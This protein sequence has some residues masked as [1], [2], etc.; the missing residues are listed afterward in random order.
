M[1]GV[2]QYIILL[3]SCC[4]VQVGQFNDLTVRAIRPLKSRRPCWT[5]EF[6]I[7]LSHGLRLPRHAHQTASGQVFSVF[8]SHKNRRKKVKTKGLL[9]PRA[10]HTVDINPKVLKNHQIV[11]GLTRRVGMWRSRLGQ[12]CS[13]PHVPPKSFEALAHSYGMH[14]K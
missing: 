1:N 10:A 9:S 3:H 14:I 11:L 13:S 2:H 7:V 4:V 6:N 5:T 8:P 12:S